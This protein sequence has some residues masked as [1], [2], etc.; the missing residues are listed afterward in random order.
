MML[1]VSLS[2]VQR[3]VSLY[4]TPLA[5]AKLLLTT[6]HVRTADLSI[7]DC[8]PQESTASDGA[9]SCR[10]IAVTHV[11]VVCLFSGVVT[12]Q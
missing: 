8:D 5:R 3:T 6:R 4:A 11:I 10:S 7:V 2:V 12:T 1:F 9:L